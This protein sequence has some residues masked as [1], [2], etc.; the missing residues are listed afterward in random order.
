[1]KLIGHFPYVNFGFCKRP[2]LEIS[3][4]NE[5]S[6]NKFIS[7]P[8]LVD[9]GADI[10]M[11]PADYAKTLGH[12]LKSVDPIVF[13]GIGGDATG[14]KHS[15][16]VEVKGKRFKCDFIFSESDNIENGILGHRD[17]FLNLIVVFNSKAGYFSLYE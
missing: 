8:C 9:T 12:D 11:L 14:Y 13:S 7:L 16:L 5:H 1:M 17:F 2:Y 4:I 10:C 15:N 6:Q 3:I